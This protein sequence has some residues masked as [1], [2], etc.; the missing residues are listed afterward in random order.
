MVLLTIGINASEPSETVQLRAEKFNRHTFWCGQSGSGK[1]YALGVVLEQLLLHTELPLLV[2]DPNA[3][4]THLN[5]AR[6]GANHGE[7]TAMSTIPMRILHTTNPDGDQ[8]R[9]RFI[10][11]S[12]AAKAAVL[13]LDP[14]ADAEEY[15][16]L[17]HTDI[18]PQDFNEPDYVASLRASGEPGEMQLANRIEN[19]QILEW[20]LWSRGG[21]SITDII[22]TRPRATVLDLG[23]FTHPAEPKVAALGML[24][25]LWSTRTQR[26]PLLIVIDE[27]HNLC[28]PNP[29]TPVERALTEQLIQIAAEGRK[30]GLW[31]FLST[32]RP[33]KIHPNV[34]SQCDNLG[35]MRLNSPRDLAEIGEVFGFVPAEML[36]DVT[37]F[38][39]GQ[40]LFAGG[41]IKD[42]TIAQMRDRVSFEGGGDVKVPFAKD[43]VSG[44]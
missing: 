22:D 37:H 24:E 23:G 6:P 15:N 3:D 25:H 42:P 32:Q 28:S 26:K 27:A 44:S 41:F 14:L 29:V 38:A 5:R 36:D 34:I 35:L 17:L 12:V 31:L 39:Q 43:T 10:D 18:A 40:N 9:T 1:T 2:L 8:V 16:V 19:L 20:D 7:A 30:F 13:R 21:E 11:L 33:T 4:F